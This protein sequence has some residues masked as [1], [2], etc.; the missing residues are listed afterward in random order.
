MRK[1]AIW[2]ANLIVMLLAAQAFVPS[3]LLYLKTIE[4]DINSGRRRERIHILS[5]VVSEEIKATQF[6]TLRDSLIKSRMKEDFKKDCSF[7]LGSHISPHYRYH[8]IDGDLSFI[9]LALTNSDLSD[10]AQRQFVL[11]CIAALQDGKYGKFDMVRQ[12]IHEI[13]S[14]KLSEE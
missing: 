7:V 5:F 1:Y 8:G 14:A 3:E 10:D 6:S 13:Y 9:A 2:I 11:E 4:V 12:R